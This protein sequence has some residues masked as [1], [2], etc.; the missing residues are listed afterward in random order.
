MEGKKNV[1]GITRLSNLQH[2]NKKIV[3]NFIFLFLCQNQKNLLSYSSIKKYYLH[4]F[5]FLGLSQSVCLDSE[6]VLPN[7]RYG[8]R[9]T[10]RANR[11][12]SKYELRFN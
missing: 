2:K 6:K 5:F 1:G 12:F 9:K 7:K 11:T 4:F 8:M 3:Q 10:H